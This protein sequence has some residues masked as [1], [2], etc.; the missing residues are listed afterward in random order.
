MNDFTNTQANF[1]NNYYGL[2]HLM[3]SVSINLGL[4]NCVFVKLL[5]YQGPHK[6]RRINLRE[7]FRRSL[8]TQ[9]AVEL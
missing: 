4:V 9:V 8:K 7:F 6:I 5:K 2:H 3:F 1:K